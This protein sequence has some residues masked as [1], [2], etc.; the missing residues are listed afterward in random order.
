MKISNNDS[1]T[2]QSLTLNNGL[3]VLLVQDIETEKSAAALTVNAGHFDD[4]QDRQGLAHFLEHMLF[5]GTDLYPEPGAFSKFTSQHGGSSNAWTGT[6]HSSYFFDIDNHHFESALKQFSRFFINPLLHSEATTKERNAIDAEFKLKLKDDSRRIYQAHKETSNPKHPFAKFSVGNADT[7]ADRDTCI[8]KEIKAFFNE[9]YI[10]L[11]MTL[12]ICSSET[13][14]Q[15]KTW[16]ESLFNDI[17]NAPNIKPE[18]SEPL[19]KA[20]H[21]KKIIYIAP[22]KHMQKIIISFAM[23]NIDAFYQHKTVSFMAHILGYEGKGSLYSILKDK[24][25][26]NSLTAGGGIN[27]S[28]FKDFNISISLTD[29]GIAHYEDIVE[30]IFTFLPLLKHD[31]NQFIPLYNDKKSLLKMAFDNQEKSKVIDF[32]NGLSINMQHYPVEDYVQGDYIMH[33]FNE[34][35]WL[36]ILN[37]LN[38]SNMRL[39]FIHP[40]VQTEKQAAWYHTPYKCDSLSKSWLSKLAEIKTPLSEM[41]LPLPNPYLTKKPHLLVV[42]TSNNIPQRLISKSGIDFWFQ[43]EQEFRIIKGHFYL[44]LDSYFT[45]KSITNMALTRLFSDLFMDNVAQEFYP[46]E[47]AGLSYQ[48]SIHQGGLTLHTSGISTNQL[49]LVKGLM[50]QLFNSKFKQQRFEEYKKQLCRHWNSGNHNKPVSQLFSLLSAKLLPWNPTPEDLSK[51]LEQVSFQQFEAFTQQ[52][53]QQ[54][55]IQALLHGNWHKSDAIK[56]YNEIDKH[57]SAFTMI[58]DLI[59]PMNIMH[60]PMLQVESLGHSDHAMVVYYQALS[61]SVDE[62]IKVMCLNHLISQDYF[63]HLRTDKQLGYLVGTG[64]APLNGRAGIAFYIQSPEVD[65]QSLLHHSHQFTQ[66]YAQTIKQ[67]PENTW[68]KAKQGL[69]TQVQEKD[70]NLRLRSLRYWLCLENQDTHFSMQKRLIEALN[71]LTQQQMFEYAKETFSDT[72]ARV[73]Y[74]SDINP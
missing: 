69:L 12:V 71:A 26:L 64:Y 8:S 52:L 41:A 22:H 50:H 23:P 51:A 66:E 43:Q 7:L 31:L 36:E 68:H 13:I 11:R 38:P 57:I 60:E 47:L 49:D 17:N 5:L 1:R 56:F 30:T 45:V 74:T 32:V 29:E 58:E 61:D 16:V 46:A 63:Q 3:K 10:A 48:L 35:Q 40:D 67:M 18:I 70:K 4:P 42:E 59:R 15:Q 65:A 34:S 62:K 21:L 33:G 37:W 2:Y 73:E 53:F 55:H 25:W 39:V 44:A 20:E 54:I 24:G 19:Y 6:E 28:N 72:R 9:H 14:A 27:G